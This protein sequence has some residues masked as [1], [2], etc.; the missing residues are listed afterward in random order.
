MSNKNK[1]VLVSFLSLFLE[2]SFI[3]W[4]PAHVFSVAFFSNIIL[5]SSFLGLGLGMLL[6]KKSCDLFRAFSVI[7]GCGVLLIL[8]L[9]YIFVSIPK[10]AQTWLWTYYEG[11]RLHLPTLKL[12]IIAVLG[13]IF[14]INTFVF[15]PLGQRIGKSMDEFTPLE[16]YTLNIAGSLLGVICFALFS[17][18]NAPAYAWFLAAALIITMALYRGRGFIISVFILAGIVL[19]IWINEKDMHWSPYFSIQLKK[20]E[21][22]SVSLYVNQSFHQ[23]AVNFDRDMPAAGKYSF[24]YKWIRPEKVL[25][26]GSGTGNDIWAALEAGAESIDAVEIDPVIV[27]L[28]RSHHPQQPYDS[29]KVRVFTDDA[30]SFMH[31]A[32]AKYDMI[33]YGTLDSHAVLSATSSVRLDNYVY[34]REAMEESKRLLSPDGIMLLLFSVP[35]E[36]IKSRLLETVKTVFKDEARYA[37]TDP[38]LF[39]MMVF[40]GPG[41]KSA[42]L[43]RPDLASALLRIS[44]E[45][46]V[47]VPTDDWPYLYLE[48]RAIPRLYI[49]A[50]LMLV[51]I[52]IAFIFMLSPL[53]GGRV[54]VFFLLL[55]CGFLLLETKSVTTMSLLFGSTWIVNA[56]VFSAILFIALAANFIVIKKQPKDARLFFVGLGFSLAISYFFPLSNLLGLGFPVKAFAAGFLA[57][58]PI[59]FAAMIFATVFRRVKYPGIALGSNLIGAV[60]G[61]F[62]EYASMISGLNFLYILALVFYFSALAVLFRSNKL[63]VIV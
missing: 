2:L 19:L 42:L 37:L 24:P 8:A 20:H 34:T 43:E 45:T 35:T 38:Y 21:D 46:R 28:G 14:F 5:I 56:V 31:K 63:E 23:K 40:A 47:D 59:F 29:D 30:R 1:L 41:L 27:E 13:I 9:Q 11:N 18:F 15:V 3:R 7:L 25:I 60:A 36:W 48:K 57:G 62:C 26:I 58:L 33:V 50:L 53:K 12:P 51:C 16:G 39:N 54:N 6:S 49:A 22:K 4:I 17:F 52:S 61:G 55:G 44:G 10:D 32:S